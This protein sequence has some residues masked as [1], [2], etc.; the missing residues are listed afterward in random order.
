M[1]RFLTSTKE[2]VTI[3]P[4]DIYIATSGDLYYV[5]NVHTDFTW[6]ISADTYMEMKEHFRFISMRPIVEFSLRE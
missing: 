6:T 5:C 1:I 4:N 2:E 3:H